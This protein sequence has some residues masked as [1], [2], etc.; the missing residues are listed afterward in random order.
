[1]PQEIENTDAAV[2]ETDGF[3]SLAAELGEE[4]VD[5]PEETE[6]TPE[7]PQEPEGT[8]ESSQEEVKEDQPEDTAP[9]EPKE[10]FPK[11]KQEDKDHQAFAK[12][13][14]EKA[15]Y[16]GLIAKLAE[17]EG[18]SVDDYE[19]K[20]HK[21]QMEA[22]AKEAQVPLEF[23]ERLK[24][25]EQ[26]DIVRQKEYEAAQFQNSIERFQNKHNLEA[27]ALRGFIDKCF[28][29]GIDITSA[30]IDLD[31]LYRGL[32]HDEMV[33]QERQKWIKQDKENRSSASNTGS[34]K[35][36][37]PKPNSGQS[38]DTMAGLEDALRGF[39]Q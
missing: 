37:T 3:E 38:I 12:L 8:D 20:V 15:R 19:A 36:T 26:A 1:M 32:N 25:L 29:N 7:T 6:E 30:G 2:T 9:E 27:P 39:K 11:D 24:Q 23:Y 28:D 16:E 31:I 33:E 4:T 13:R 10:G 34:G 21:D 14:V 5:A 17:K 22:E 18:L 35:G